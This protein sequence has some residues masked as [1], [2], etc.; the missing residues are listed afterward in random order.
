MTKSSDSCK[1]AILGGGP[2][3]CACALSL[4]MENPQDVI[5]VDAEPAMPFR[6]GETVPPEIN[7][8]LR[9][10]GIYHEFSQEGHLPCYGSVSY[11]GSPKRG[12]N[13]FILSPYGHGWHLDRSAFN[14][15]MV[16]Q[17]EKK[18]HR[19]LGQTTYKAARR[20]ESN[21]WDLHLVDN[22]GKM[23]TLNASVVVDA[24]G[25]RA[26]FATQQGRKK[27]EDQG[28]ICTVTRFDMSL[29]NQEVSKTTHLEAFRHGWFYATPL[30]DKVFLLALFTDV[31]TVKR[32]GLHYQDGWMQMLEKTEHTK[33][34]IKGM[35]AM[36]SR[37]LGF[38]APSYHLDV[39]YGKGWLAIGDSAAAYDPITSGGI[40]KAL[41]DGM[42][43]ASAIH[44]F[45]GQGENFSN[46]GAECERRN[47]EYLERRETYYHA[48]NR[49][50]R[51]GFWKKMQDATHTFRPQSI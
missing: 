45:F 32:G 13:D 28:L 48:E 31:E 14:R 37:P 33:L 40:L 15:F 3:G 1:V 39:P 30:P 44:K 16:K 47:N 29:K 49:W 23:I 26:S 24:T 46:Y 51:G 19:V 25:Q 42:R 2:A 20:S 5:L 9:K 50:N 41:S 7:E 43:S 8:A 22:M 4:Q 12:Y 36:D 35:H 21:S 38:A 27:L 6:I 10:L 11:W 17:V 34:L 18:G